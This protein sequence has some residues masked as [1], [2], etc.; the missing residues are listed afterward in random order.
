MLLS[1][2]Q[3][4]PTDFTMA[5]AL[6][7]QYNSAAKNLIYGGG[8]ATSEPAHHGKKIIRKD[9]P[10]Q[11]PFATNEGGANE[12]D[13]KA[14]PA[15]EEGHGAL[16][17]SKKAHREIVGKVGD[18]TLDSDIYRQAIAENAANKEAQLKKNRGQN[19]LAHN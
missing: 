5:A 6:D 11:A 2:R 1:C 17:K 12:E 10:A 15:N 14:K 4:Q 19:P 8:P 13:K 9:Q 18:S 16:L 3:T 7:R